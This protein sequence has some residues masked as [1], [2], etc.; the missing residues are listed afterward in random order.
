[1]NSASSLPLF[2]SIVAHGHTL[3]PVVPCGR[4]LLLRLMA[5][6][7]LISFPFVVCKFVAIATAGLAVA[8]VMA[9]FTTG[10]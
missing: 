6:L 5:E 9:G 3:F 8:V 10:Q 2:V 7:E 1:M 4:A